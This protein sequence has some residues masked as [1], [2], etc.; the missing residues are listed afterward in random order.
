MFGHLMKITFFISENPTILHVKFYFC[1]VHTRKKN[2]PSFSENF[3]NYKNP[4]YFLQKIHY[5]SIYLG[6]GER[7]YNIKTYFLSFSGKL[8]YI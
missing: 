1:T 4:P 6:E 7:N 8:Q 2:K 5:L 3:K